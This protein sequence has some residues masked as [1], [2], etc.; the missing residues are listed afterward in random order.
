MND[1]TLVDTRPRTVY[2]HRAAD[3]TVLYV[4]ATVNL[5]TRT[6]DHK[7][8]SPWWAQ[9]ATVETETVVPEGGEWRI[10]EARLIGEAR[11]PYNKQCHGPDGNWRAALAAHEATALSETN[12]A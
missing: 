5:T 9:V 7:V 10:V 11:P 4:G 12:A 2:S 8:E 6:H 3:G 1:Y